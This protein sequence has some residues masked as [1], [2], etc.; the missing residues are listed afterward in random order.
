MNLFGTEDYLPEPSSLEPVMIEH[1]RVCHFKAKPDEDGHKR[2]G[3]ACCGRAKHDPL[4][5][6]TPKSI[7]VFGSGNPRLYWEMKRRW[8]AILLPLLRGSGMPLGLSRVMVDGELTFPDRGRRD[9]GNFRVVLEKAL[10]DTL[11]AGGW[12]EDDD[13]SR[14]EFGNLTAN[15]QKGV[16]AT[17]LMIWPVLAVTG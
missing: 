17:R 15:Y 6:G 7:N 3:C 4:H 11:T 5:Y 14:Y 1:V 16:S 2:L 9:Q 13:W 10:G 12:L 8:S